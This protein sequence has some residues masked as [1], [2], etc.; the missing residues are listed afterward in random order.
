MPDDFSPPLLIKD[1][2][3]YRQCIRIDSPIGRVYECPDGNIV[4]SVTSILSKT[5]D[6]SGLEQWRKFKGEKAANDIT[7][8]AAAI[9]TALHGNIERFV[10]G[11]KRMLGNNYID[12]VANKMG[13]EI[14]KHGLSKVTEVYALEQ[15]LYYPSLYS[16]TTD[17]IGLYDGELSVIDFKQ[18]NKIKKSEY[19]IDYRLQ[20]SAYILAHNTLYGTNINRGIVMMCTRNHEYLQFDVTSDDIDKWTDMWLDRVGDFYKLG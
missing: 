18:S 20:L 8:E 17:M 1:R 6:K 14:I 10:K 5:G 19:V 16:G 7:K 3:N 15:H 11:E 12:N 13:D 2:F 9:G 4:P